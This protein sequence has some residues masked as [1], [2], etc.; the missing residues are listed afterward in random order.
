MATII[1]FMKTYTI[2][3]LALLTS[4][5]IFSQSAEFLQNEA[6]KI[7]QLD[8]QADFQ[9]EEVYVVI[10]NNT[11][12][13][14]NLTWTRTETVLPEGWESAICDNVRCWL[15]SVSSKPFSINSKDT[16][17]FII[18]LYPNR[19][20]GDSAVIDLV[21]AN[22]EDPNDITTLSVT[23]KNGPITSNDE[24]N[25][26]VSDIQLYPNPASSFT[27][28]KDDT[29]LVERSELYSVTGARL[30]ERAVKNNDQ[31]NT[32]SL[33]PG[34]YILRLYDKNGRLLTSKRLQKN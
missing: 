31:I 19:V 24:V 25:L 17:S 12:D 8:E 5:Q 29:G 1:R 6:S 11:F 32:S 30:D 14:L 4:G 7:F 27:I 20:P 13:E 22:D 23:F 2:F 15:P 33:N 18:H 10:Q 34:N 9:D 3:L 26:A 28:L 21:V 16:F